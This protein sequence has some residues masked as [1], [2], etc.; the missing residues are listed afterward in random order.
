[1]GNIDSCIRQFTYD[2][3]A[4]GHWK[5][6]SAIIQIYPEVD[7]TAI[8]IRNSSGLGVDPQTGFFSDTENGPDVYDE[9]NLVQDNFNNPWAKIQG[10]SYGK[11]L[12][13]ITEYDESF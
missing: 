8:G 9:I 1:M 3:F 2:N 7:Y 11:S 4:N 12:P 6:T 5:D 10:P 13:T